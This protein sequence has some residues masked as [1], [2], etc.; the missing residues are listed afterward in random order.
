MENFNI[1]LLAKQG[2]RLIKHP[3]SL[4]ARVFKAKYYRHSSFL[5][6]KSYT[7]SSYGWRSIIQ[8]QKLLKQGSKWIVGDG[9]DI[10]VW[11]DNWI[12]AKPSS[13][14]SGPGLNSHPGLKVNDLL[15]ERDRQ[16]NIQLLKNLLNENDANYAM[17]I[18]PSRT[19]NPDIL[20]WSYTKD[21]NYSV[22]TGYHLQCQMEEQN[23]SLNQV[24][25]PE[26]VRKCCSNLW[27]LKI[28]P[29]LK[30]FWWRVAHNSLAVM[31]NIRKR[32]ITID[33]TCQT[34]GENI[35]TLNHMMFECRV[36]KEIWEMIPTSFS[37]STNSSENLIG[38]VNYL[39]DRVKLDKREVLN[40]FAGWNIWKMRN[41]ISF[42]H[43]RDHILKVIHAAI[44]EY[45]FWN[46]AM[47]AE[48]SQEQSTGVQNN[49]V[50]TI[51]E[52]LPPLTESY[53]L[54]DASWKSDQELA[55]IGWSFHIKEGIQK[56]KG[57]SS[58]KPTNTSIEAEAMAMLMAV[59]QIKNL[60][61]ENVAFISDCKQLIDELNQFYTEKNITSMRVT[62][63][64][65]MIRDIYSMSKL[66]NFTF[67]FYV[68]ISFN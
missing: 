31:D 23:S 47:E 43:K 41:N 4:L 19:G 51:H 57:S 63:A 3:Q 25:I 27:K 46:E 40:F 59:Q 54:V 14:A 42:Q 53:C 21:G 17:G 58:I 50:K 18:R 65:S 35:E 11:E 20:V 26:E 66:C 12:K 36:A 1:A 61:Y 67:H 15:I 28:P 16:W 5:Q 2:W 38:N 7:T 6:A 60:G 8:T 13:P 24:T 55:G 52:V 62:E 49:Q 9:K 32:G 68:S 10:R 33:N 45:Q 22:K 48:N 34:C 30:T 56:L 39:L 37:V 64:S 29:K 44:R